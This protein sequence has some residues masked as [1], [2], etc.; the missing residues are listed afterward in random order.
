MNPTRP[1]INVPN[2]RILGVKPSMNMNSSKGFNLE[3]FTILVTYARLKK[4][5]MMVTD[6]EMITVEEASRNVKMH[7]VTLAF[8]T[9]CFN[10]K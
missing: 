6:N 7:M 1:P 9:Q 5:L 10:A 4:P 3:F 2:I 8:Q